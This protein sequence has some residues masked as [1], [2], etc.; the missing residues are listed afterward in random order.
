[1]TTLRQK[2]FWETL[3]VIALTI[4][5][6]CIVGLLTS[7]DNSTA[8]TSRY[9][10]DTSEKWLPVKIDGYNGEIGK[11]GYDGHTYIVFIDIYRS[12]MTHDPDCVKCHGKN[13]NK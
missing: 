5:I 12:G 2:R 9:N 3:A 8:P 7:C 1:M 13:D 11:I 6:C 10:L 4:G